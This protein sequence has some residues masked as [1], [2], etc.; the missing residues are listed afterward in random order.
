MIPNFENLFSVYHREICQII[1]GSQFTTRLLQQLCTVGKSNQESNMLNIVPN[2]RKA[3]ETLIYKVKA[4]LEANDSLE[5]FWQG[6][7]KIK[8][9]EGKVDSKGDATKNEMGSKND[10]TNSKN[11]ET[12]SKNNEMDSKNDEMDSKN[13][14]MD[15]KNHE[16]FK[17][18]EPTSG[19][20]KSEDEADILS[21]DANTELDAE[22][23][24]EDEDE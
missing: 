16:V 15:S 22:N 8:N 21:D 12:N 3:L 23:A 13:N 17:Y 19:D 2:I 10:E 4:I 1:R 9:L 18:I 6:N 7:L 24:E 11:D 20:E 14:E 5:A